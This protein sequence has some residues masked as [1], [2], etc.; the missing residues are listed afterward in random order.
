MNIKT[1]SLLVDDAKILSYCFNYLANF[2][3][4]C[5]FSARD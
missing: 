5:D 1:I 4:M 2:K 3:Q